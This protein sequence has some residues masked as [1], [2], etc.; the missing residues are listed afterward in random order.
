MAETTSEDRSA[1]SFTELVT[2]AW[3][4]TSPVHRSRTNLLIHIIAVPLFVLGHVLLIASVIDPW[5]LVGAVLSIV[6]SLTAQK[7]GHSLEHHQVHAFTGAPDFLRR[8]YAEQFCN[9]WRFLFSGEWY[10]SYK[11]SRSQV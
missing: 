5:L 3:R 2:W 1:V 9:F 10:A 7:Y 6:I 11:A 8:L 4:E